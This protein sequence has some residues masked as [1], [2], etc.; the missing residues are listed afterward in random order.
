MQLLVVE[1]GL[2]VAVGEVS[3]VIASYSGGG[4]HIR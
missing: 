1:L 4:D 3:D 2:K